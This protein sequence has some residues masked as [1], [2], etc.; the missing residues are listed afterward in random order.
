MHMLFQGSVWCNPPISSMLHTVFAGVQRLALTHTQFWLLMM[1]R[2]VGGATWEWALV[3]SHSKPHDGGPH[4]HLWWTYQ[5]HLR[6]STILFSFKT[7]SSSLVNLPSAT[8]EWALEHYSY[9]HS[10]PHPHLMLVP[11]TYHRRCRTGTYSLSTWAVIRRPPTP[12]GWSYWWSLH[13]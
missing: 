11:S 3:Y 8:W 12:S 6:V 10:K 4:P 7:P 9:S 2:L 5:R 13:F 1:G